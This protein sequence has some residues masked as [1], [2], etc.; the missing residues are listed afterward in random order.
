LRPF[1]ANLK[2]FLSSQ[3]SGFLISISI[4]MIIQNFLSSKHSFLYIIHI[5]M[6]KIKKLCKSPIL[7]HNDIKYISQR[8]QVFFCET[9]RLG[10]LKPHITI[11][12]ETMAFASFSNLRS[13]KKKTITS[14]NETGFAS[15]SNF[16]DWT[17]AEISC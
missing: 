9:A 17:S 14:L 1:A 5:R 11:L 2:P 4:T 12:N 6:S 3:F 10:G 8:Q 7:L 16:R 15:F 13:I